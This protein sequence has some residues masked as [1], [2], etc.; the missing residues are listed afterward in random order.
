[1]EHTGAFIDYRPAPW[2]AISADID[3]SYTGKAPAR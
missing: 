1:M 2:P 3:A